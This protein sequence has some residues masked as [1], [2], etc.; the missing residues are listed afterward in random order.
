MF[1][2]LNTTLDFI[3]PNGPQP[4]EGLSID[5]GVPV[6]FDASGGTLQFG[7]AQNAE[8]GPSSQDLLNPANYA[9]GGV[10]VGSSTQENSETAF[11][12]DGD[13]DNSDLNPYF[14]VIKAG[15]GWNKNKA[16]TRLGFSFG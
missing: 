2:R 5:N 7:I 13:Y 16:E 10:G 11:R 4:S 6:E 1:P 3:N 9:L 12:L 8:F 15:V 14:S